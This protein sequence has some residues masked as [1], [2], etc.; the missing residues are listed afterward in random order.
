MHTISLTAFSCSN[1]YGVTDES[2]NKLQEINRK[3]SEFQSSPAVLNSQISNH[4]SRTGLPAA[5]D[6]LEIALHNA[7]LDGT[8][9]FPPLR[10]AD[11]AKRSGTN[12]STGKN[13][14]ILK[15]HVS[16]SRIYICLHSQ[17]SISFLY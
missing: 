6:D 9:C 12:S 3:L 11:E 10:K 14:N 2:Q 8:P 13:D 7:Y 17:G 1:R 5:N 4:L 15:K 16:D